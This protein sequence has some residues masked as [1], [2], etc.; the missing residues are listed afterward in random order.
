M[1][2][3]DL[4]RDMSD[5]IP[6]GLSRDSEFIFRRMTEATLDAALSGSIANNLPAGGRRIL[7]V[8]CGV[9][10]DSIAL[11]ARGALVVGAEPSLRMIGMARLFAE[12]KQVEMPDWIQCWSDGLP[13]LC[14]E[15]THQYTSVAS[16]TKMYAAN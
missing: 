9:G 2:V 7:D 1:R 13:W 16:R 3:V 4:D 11:S 6:T 10:Q 14:T 15:A 8:A 12:E 5:V